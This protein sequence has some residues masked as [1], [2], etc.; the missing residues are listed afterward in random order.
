MVLGEGSAQTLQ[1][2][3]ILSFDQ[4]EHKRN[5]AALMATMGF[6]QVAEECDI[7]HSKWQTVL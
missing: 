6:S 7:A 4:C 5:G 1:A 2:Y 3:E